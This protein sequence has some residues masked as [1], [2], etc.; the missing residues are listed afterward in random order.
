MEV[1]MPKITLSAPKGTPL[2]SRL[3]LQI[4]CYFPFMPPTAA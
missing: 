2:V 4:R 1:G 3:H